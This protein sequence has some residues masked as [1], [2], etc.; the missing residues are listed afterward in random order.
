MRRLAGVASCGLLA[1]ALTAGCAAGAHAPDQTAFA[2]C[3][4]FGLRAIQR[5]VTVAAKPRECAGL[6]HEQVN[7]AVSRA[8]R[9]AVGPEP[10]V[11]ARRLADQDSAYLIAGWLASGGWRRRRFAGLVPV[12]VLGHFGFAVAG[13]GIWLAF[14]ITGTPILAWIAVGL[15]VLIGG[16]GMGVLSAAL[17]DPSRGTAPARGAAPVTII[18][19]HGILA[20]ATI[21]LVLTAAIDAR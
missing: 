11:V 13:L 10:K 20:T 15:L 14:V 18:A 7:M 9:E 4:A 3:V 19:I 16:L 1:A 12:T 5:H 17:P 8:V 6:S 2:T 21:V